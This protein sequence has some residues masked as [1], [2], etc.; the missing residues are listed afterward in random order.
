VNVNTKDSYF[1]TESSERL[2]QYI[3]SV[4]AWLENTK[5]NI[6]LVE[7]SGYA[8][9][10]LSKE[11]EKYRGR[12]EILSFNGMDTAPEFILASRDK[13][14]HELFSINYALNNSRLVNSDFVIKVTGRYYIPGFQEY[15]NTV[16]LGV[17]DSIVQN[18]HASNSRCEMIG[19]HAKHLRE[20]FSL[21]IEPEYLTYPY[22]V[23]ESIYKKRI[24]EYNRTLE[25]KEFPIEATICCGNNR[26][27]RHI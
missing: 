11:V 22:N 25:C 20:L 10:E 23:V 3:K 14:L 7:N 12:F 24:G 26:I 9:Q 17:Y 5:Y 13:G 4:R 21:T 16:N 15:T 8:F 6:V 2:K 18:G 27:Y 19:C 1:L